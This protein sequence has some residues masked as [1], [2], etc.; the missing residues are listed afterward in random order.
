MH[1][2]EYGDEQANAR[3]RSLEH[4]IEALRQRIKEFE[5]PGQPLPS[6][7]STS[8]V[9]AQAP[10]QDPYPTPD[11]LSNQDKT[12]TSVSISRTLSPTGLSPAD[13]T[14]VSSIASH[15]SPRDI[16]PRQG[17][18]LPTPDVGRSAFYVHLI[19]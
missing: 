6:S 10:L 11:S 1:P 4:E 17:S 8:S 3:M 7:S 14:D 13:E 2:C 16:G 5:N 12:G 18:R 19:H 9:A 15:L